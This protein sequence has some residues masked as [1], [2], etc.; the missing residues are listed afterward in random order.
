ML[1][2][3][4]LA[5]IKRRKR[6]TSSW[7]KIGIAMLTMLWVLFLWLFIKTPYLANP[8]FVSKALKNDSLDKSIIAM[9]S[10]FL[11]IVICLVF[12][13]ISVF[14]L[15]GFSIINNEKKYLEIID[16]LADD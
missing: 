4:E 2:K 10:L 12:L 7:Q 11:P 14:I 8:F 5:F 6:L 1:D 16:N 15:L 13:T 3:K 9:S